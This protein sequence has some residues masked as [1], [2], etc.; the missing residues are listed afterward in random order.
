MKVA[1]W[2]LWDGRDKEHQMHYRDVIKQ[3]PK[4]IRLVRNQ[5]DLDVLYRKMKKCKL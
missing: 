5:R 1:K 4:K 3:Y 2:I